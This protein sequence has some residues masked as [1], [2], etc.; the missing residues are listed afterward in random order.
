MLPTA[1]EQFCLACQKVHY[2][3]VWYFRGRP[4]DNKR[5]WLCGMKYLV[6]PSLAMDTWT[7]L[8][9]LD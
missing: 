5:E 9:S 7:M 1:I 8:P 2:S 3:T 6:L 4:F